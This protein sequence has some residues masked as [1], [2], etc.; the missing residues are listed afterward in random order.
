[1]TTGVASPWRFQGRILESTAGSDTYDFGAR[2]YVPDLGTFTSLDSLAGSAQNPITLNRYLYA[3]ANPVTLV[4]PDGHR[5][6]YDYGTDT[7][8]Y[9]AANRV[10]VNWDALSNERSAQAA[11]LKKQ[12]KQAAIDAAAA[13][14]AANAA[15]NAHRDCGFMGTGCIDLGGAANFV[16][17]A[18]QHTGG[19][20]VNFE[21]QL[22]QDTGGAAVN[23]IGTGAQ[24]LA[25]H[26]EVIVAGVILVA[27]CIAACE[28]LIPAAMA[29]TDVAGFG[30]LVETSSFA[31]TAALPALET[32][33]VPAISFSATVIHDTVN[34]EVDDPTG[35][36]NDP[37]T[38]DQWGDGDL[39]DTAG[40]YKV[41]NPSGNGQ[42]TTW[43]NFVQ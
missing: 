35:G 29:F 39:H 13:A 20:Y 11:A 33:A 12:R 36:Y 8:T 16:N 34:P 19:A 22:W 38:V 41:R 18:W 5:M 43:S 6:L 2:A 7:G 42:F 25:N 28:M 24:W 27:A 31:A 1:M 40:N 9:A 14:K 4:D 30:G 10:F 26:P 23:D 21:N 15:A 37:M 32:L 3:L 17:Q